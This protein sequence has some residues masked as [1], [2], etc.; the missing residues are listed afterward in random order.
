M[1][2]PPTFPPPMQLSPPIPLP[3]KLTLLDFNNI[4]NL[5]PPPPPLPVP[6]AV[7]F[8]VPALPGKL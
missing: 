8:A 4:S 6:V 2:M 3:S 1:P 5:V 7:P